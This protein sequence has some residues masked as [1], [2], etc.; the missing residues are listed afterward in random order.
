MITIII[1]S[2]NSA[3]VDGEEVEEAE[4]RRKRWRTVRLPKRLLVRLQR[5]V[6]EKFINV[7]EPPCQPELAR[8]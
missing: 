7:Y 2:S 3:G 8:C 1:G 4:R 5:M 6:V